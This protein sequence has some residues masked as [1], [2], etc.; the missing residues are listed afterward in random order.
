MAPPNRSL[1]KP[2]EVVRLIERFQEMLLA[3]RGLSLRSLAAYK[4]DILAFCKFKQEILEATK[5][6]IENYVGVLK[7]EGRRPSSIMRSI[8][9]LRQF[10]SFLYDEKD[11]QQNPTID[12]KMRAVGKPLPKVLSEEEVELLLGYFEKN[13]DLRLNAMLHILY[14]AGLRVSELVTLTKDSII[15]CQESGRVA[16]LIRGKGDRERIVHLNHLAIEAVESY[17]KLVDVTHRTTKYLFPSP[18]KHGHLTR[19]GFA[20][21]LK[22]LAADVGIPVTK[23]SPHVIRHAFATHLLLHGADLLSI[24]KLL[25]HKDISTTQ[26]YTHVSNEKIRK[27]V[28][29]NPNISKLHI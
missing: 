25:G 9:A 15:R 5:T 2:S 14:G 10:F 17:T 29:A 18:S 20:K 28:E 6:D 21:L 3:E 26:I 4:S 8:A 22:K 11:I 16:L 1:S 12:I 24:Q 27:L 23:V 7:A 19:Q 13:E